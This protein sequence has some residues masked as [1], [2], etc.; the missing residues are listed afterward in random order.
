MDRLVSRHRPVAAKGE[1]EGNVVLWVGEG[2]FS[3]IQFIQCTV[4]H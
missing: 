4:C 2:I 1:Q 3:D